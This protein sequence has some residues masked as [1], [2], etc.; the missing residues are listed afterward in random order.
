MDFLMKEN[1]KLPNFALIM[2][3]DFLNQKTLTL[4]DEKISAIYDSDDDSIKAIAKEDMIE[5]KD[6]IRWLNT[7]NGEKDIFYSLVA[8]Q[9]FFL[10]RNSFSINIELTINKLMGPLPLVKFRNGEIVLMNPHKI[11]ISLDGFEIDIASSNWELNGLTTISI[12]TA[13]DKEEGPTINVSI[14]E[15][16]SF[17]FKNTLAQ[18]MEVLGFLGKIPKDNIIKLIAFEFNDYSGDIKHSVIEEPIAEEEDGS[19]IEENDVEIFKNLVIEAKNDKIFESEERIRLTYMRILKKFGPLPHEQILRESY[20][21]CGIADRKKT[22]YTF[23]LVEDKYRTFEFG[24][25][26]NETATAEK[27]LYLVMK[28]P[29]WMDRIKIKENG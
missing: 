1:N 4:F 12:F 17:A 8:K 10:K 23:E 29:E 24:D 27:L 20:Y 7:E 11:F 2:R 5:L 25:I 19:E 18:D 13:H 16:P 14:N 15:Q 3:F 9:P 26:T 6:N 21:I 28:Y 22:S